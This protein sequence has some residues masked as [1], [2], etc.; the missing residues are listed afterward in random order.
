MPSH[1]GLGLHDDQGC[2]PVPPGVGEPYPKESIP[3]AKLRPLPDARQHGQL[4]TERRVFQRDRSM[5]ARDQSD[6]AQK[7]EKPGQHA[8]SCRAF[9]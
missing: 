7:Y 9:R 3:R 8:L 4:L 1:D 6:E 5:T 2:A